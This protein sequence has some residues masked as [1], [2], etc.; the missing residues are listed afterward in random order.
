MIRVLLVA[1]RT[2]LEYAD[3]EVQ[4][5]AN[6]LQPRL[7]IGRVTTERAME[8][9]RDEYDWVFWL[10]HGR[11][12]GLITDDGVLDL[13]ILTSLLRPTNAS[14]LVL[15]TCSSAAVAIGLSRALPNLRVVA[16]ISDVPDRL[17]FVTSAQFAYHLSQ[18]LSGEEAYRHIDAG[19]NYIFLHGSQWETIEDESDRMADKTEDRK[20][21][22]HDR[23]LDEHG[24]RLVRV[25]TRIDTLW[26]FWFGPTRDR[27]PPWVIFVAAIV[28][29]LLVLG[30]LA[31]LA[32]GGINAR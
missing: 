7:L 16:T 25:E 31:V 6:L 8:A 10:G 23:R 28:G 3:A 2:D 11:P 1:P 26:E 14:G 15:N 19:T 12:E 29:F 4:Q 5:I 24:D 20:L 22:E 27:V 21:D 18:G 30:I 32:T 13:Q 9:L 17:A